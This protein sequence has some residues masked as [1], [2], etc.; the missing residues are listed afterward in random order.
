MDATTFG[1]LGDRLFRFGARRADAGIGF[2]VDR[3]SS[4]NAVFPTRGLGRFVSYVSKRDSPT[5]IDL[6]PVV[7]ANVSFFG[8]QLGCKLIVEDLFAEL[9]RVARQVQQK[10]IELVS[11][12][13]GRLDHLPGSADGVLCWDLFD[14]LDQPSAESLARQ[15]IEVLKPGGAVFALF[16]GSNSGAERYT[17]YAIMDREHLEHRPYKATRGKGRTWGSRDVFK[18]FHGLTIG[19]TYLLKIQIREMLFR[20]PQAAAQV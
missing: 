7:G 16:G 20:K 14:Y 6:G 12:I 13:N 4:E 15:V 11:A 3:D 8:E 5:I 19:E 9:E 10:E 17:K 1:T 2:S 18:L